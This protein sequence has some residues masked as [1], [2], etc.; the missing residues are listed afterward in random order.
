MAG[1]VAHTKKNAL[2][3]SVNVFCM[4]VLIGDTILMS[5]TGDGF[6]ILRWSSEPQKTCE[7]TLMILYTD[8]NAVMTS[9]ENV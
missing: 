5:I 4:K 1:H 6:A 2:Y 3:L 7:F 9:N 8:S